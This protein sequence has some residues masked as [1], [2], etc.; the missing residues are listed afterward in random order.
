[1][2]AS[3]KKAKENVF[4]TAR[5]AV[6]V[7]REGQPL[8]FVHRAMMTLE[9]ALDNYDA[10]KNIDEE[11]RAEILRKSR[12]TLVKQVKQEKLVDKVKRLRK[13][14]ESRRRKAKK[15]KEKQ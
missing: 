7:Y 3:V 15:K 6:R 9:F 2:K 5:E 12:E 11:E 1:M 14:V 8:E 13:N 4:A 10:A